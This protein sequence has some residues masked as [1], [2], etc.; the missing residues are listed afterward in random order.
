[1]YI[2]ISPHNVPKKSPILGKVFSEC[3]F[4]QTTKSTHIFMKECRNVE[5]K[6]RHFCPR[7]VASFLEKISRR[8]REGVR[9]NALRVLRPKSPHSEDYAQHIEWRDPCGHAAVWLQGSAVQGR[10]DRPRSDI[11][12]DDG[13][14]INARGCSRR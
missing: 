5:N 3:F 13:I 9:R 7:G 2:I 14:T 4:G 6:N 12:K 10:H 1:M 8:Y 11:M